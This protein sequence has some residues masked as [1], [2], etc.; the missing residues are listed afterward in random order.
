[1]NVFSPRDEGR[2][3]AS[4]RVREWARPLLDAGDEDT[5]VVTELR[6]TEPGCPPVE[7]MIALLRARAEPRKVTI[8]KPISEITEADVR[9]ALLTAPHHD[10]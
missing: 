7:T 1:L 8:H 2:A 3:A 10:H 5:V 9:A 6:C 4:R